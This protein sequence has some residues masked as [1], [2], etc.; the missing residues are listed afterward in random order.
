FSASGTSL[1]LSSY[2]GG[3][4]T[5][6]GYA[7]GIDA[8]NQPTIAGVTSSSDLPTYQPFQASLATLG[9]DAFVSRFSSTGTLSYSSYY[10]GNS[11][12]AAPGLA[13]LPDGSAFLAGFTD[14]SSLPGVSG[15]YSGSNAGGTDAFLAKVLQGLATPAITGI[16]TDTGYSNSDKIT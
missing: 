2:L 15:G 14:S 13:L 12:D 4:G 10:G 16:S 8:Q 5:D 11:T 9:Y 1:A 6:I 3:L 7:I